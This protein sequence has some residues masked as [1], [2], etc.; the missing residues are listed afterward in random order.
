MATNHTLKG[1][2]IAEFLGQVF[3][4]SLVAV[5]SQQQN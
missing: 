2:C 3:L 1:A 5:V 4:F